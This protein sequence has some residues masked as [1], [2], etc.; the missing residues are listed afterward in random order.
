MLVVA[1]V[2]LALQLPFT[3]IPLIKATSSHALMGTFA[4][5]RLHAASAWAASFLIFAANLAML[6]N[7]LRADAGA[8]A[9][10]GSAGVSGVWAWLRH[11]AATTTRCAFQ[12]RESFE[13]VSVGVRRCMQLTG[14]SGQLAHAIRRK[15]VRFARL[16]LSRSTCRLG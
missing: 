11:A 5:S 9:A 1:Q 14:G 15:H 16:A 4:S 8:A 10:G 6:A 12:A 13:T 7:W 2:V 3:L